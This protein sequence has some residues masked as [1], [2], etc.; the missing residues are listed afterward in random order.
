MP[1]VAVVGCGV[2]GSSWA[3]VF[4]R[5]GFDVNVYDQSE[6]AINATLTFVG[7][8]LD[9]LRAQGLAGTETGETVLARLTPMPKLAEALSGIDYVQ[10][11]APERVEIK[12]ELYKQLDSLAAPTT[13]L[14]SSTSGLPASSFTEG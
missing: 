9:D 5:A 1:R 7:N 14:A 12:R 11:S 6:A 2:V 4:A 10:E 3:L 13:V 8:A